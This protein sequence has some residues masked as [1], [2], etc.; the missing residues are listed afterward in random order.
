MVPALFNA[1]V[2]PSTTITDTLKINL[3][4][5]LSPSTIV[6]S[7]NAIVSTNGTAVVTLPSSVIGN[8]YYVEVSHRNA[9]ATWSALPVTFG[10]TTNYNFTTSV[11]Q[12][13]GSNMKLLAPGI[14]GFY[15]GDLQPKDETCDILDQ[16]TLDNHIFNFASGYLTSDLNG[17]GTIDIVDQIFLDNNIAGFVGSMHP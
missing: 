5:A 16:T 3:H 15:S 4:D 1:G 2:S 9:I 17:D 10:A 8:S 11:T 7:S 6:A 13:Y 12:A 14:F